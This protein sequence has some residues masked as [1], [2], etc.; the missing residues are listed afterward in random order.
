VESDRRLDG[1]QVVV[2][3]ARVDGKELGRES[4]SIASKG[5][6][7]HWVIGK[8]QP[9]DGEMERRTEGGKRK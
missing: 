5:I 9:R 4:E 3:A 7:G 2:K 1:R 6:E 8:K